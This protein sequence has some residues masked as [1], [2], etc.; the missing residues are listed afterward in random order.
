MA[1]Y[2][3]NFSVLHYIPSI[4]QASIQF[5]TTRRLNPQH[6]LTHP[7]MPQILGNL[8]QDIIKASY[9]LPMKDRHAE[10]RRYVHAFRFSI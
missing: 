4:Q 1:S 7:Q 10:V 5:H 9:L 8:V 3:H 6:I 2:S